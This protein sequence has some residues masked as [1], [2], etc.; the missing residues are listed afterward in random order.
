MP[1]E[2]FDGEGY[3]LKKLG[4][5]K[6]YKMYLTIPDIRIPKLE[7]GSKIDVRSMIMDEGETRPPY[8]YN[9]GSLIQEMDRLGL[10]TKST[11]HDIIGKLYSRNYVQGNYMV[12]YVLPDRL[13][14]FLDICGSLGYGCRDYYPG[15]NPGYVGCYTFDVL[16]AEDS[17]HHRHLPV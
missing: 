15:G 10:G 6:Y 13:L 2:Q 8:R 17:E 5:K 12:L 7:I 4:W 11:R 1:G 14:H 9:Q 3:V 16:V